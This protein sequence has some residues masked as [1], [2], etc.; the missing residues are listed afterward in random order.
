MN[1]PPDVRSQNTKYERN[2][3]YDLIKRLRREPSVSIRKKI[4]SGTQGIIMTAIL[5]I[6]QPHVLSYWAWA[7]CGL[8]GPF[9]QTDLTLHFLPEKFI[10]I[11]VQ[12]VI[13]FHR[14]PKQGVVRVHLI[15]NI[16]KEV[17]HT[18]R[19]E[20][21]ILNE[22]QELHNSAKKHQ[23]LKNATPWNLTRLPQ[24]HTRW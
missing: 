12:F 16:I 14:T 13:C 18:K 17:Y 10:R 9:S 22:A 21:K 11:P 1:S 20:L 3:A 5:K 6:T 15:T 4:S 19:S 2:C 24:M 8:C 7:A 23:T